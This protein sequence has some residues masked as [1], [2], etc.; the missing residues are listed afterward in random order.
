MQL[1]HNA[2]EAV[3]NCR[4]KGEDAVS[5]WFKRYHPG[6]KNPHEQKRSG[7]PK[8]VYSEVLL[9]V[10]VANQV[11]LGEYHAS[12]V[13]LSCA[14]HYLNDFGKTSRGTEFCFPLPKYCKTFD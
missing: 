12:L 8:S 10:I 2:A 9:Q 7:K 4:T 11:A 1:S 5:L 13:T 6:R 14:V 3:K